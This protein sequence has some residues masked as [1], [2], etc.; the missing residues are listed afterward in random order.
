MDG[1]GQ[2]VGNVAVTVTNPEPVRQPNKVVIHNKIDNL[3]GYTNYLCNPICIR[4]KDEM[5][6]ADR[7]PQRN[8]FS[9]SRPT[10]LIK[11]LIKRQR[12]RPQA[13]SRRS[14]MPGVVRL[15]MHIKLVPGGAGSTDAGRTARA[16]L[17]WVRASDK[18]RPGN[19]PYRRRSPINLYCK[20][21]RK[22]TRAIGQHEADCEKNC[23]GPIGMKYRGQNSNRHDP[24]IPDTSPTNTPKP[25]QYS[26]VAKKPSIHVQRPKIKDAPRIPKH[27]TL[28]VAVN[29]ESGSKTI[30]QT[31]KAVF[32]AAQTY[33]TILSEIQRTPLTQSANK[34]AKARNAAMPRKTLP[35]T[36]S[37]DCCMVLAGHPLRLQAR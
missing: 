25:P 14:S 33:Q 27:E 31:Q 26:Y 36:L 29:S 28:R 16:F 7:V 9:Q 13:P 1:S 24:T 32:A 12:Q 6:G 21:H 18:G 35:A 23:S 19:R 20:P 4:V 34:N 10:Q 15:R 37:A 22:R 2:E 11:R 17:L 3:A 5:E 8:L 30:R